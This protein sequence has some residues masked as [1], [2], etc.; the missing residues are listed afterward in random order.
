MH[1]EGISNIVADALSRYFMEHPE[2]EETLPHQKVNVD[3]RLDPE[4]EAIPLDRKAEILQERAIRVSAARRQ[5]RKPNTRDETLGEP[6]NVE[7]ED[8]RAIDH[9]TKGEPLSVRVEGDTT[10]VPFI[11]EGYAQDSTFS[12]V[13]EHPREHPRFGVKDGLIW[14]KNLLKRDTLCVPSSAQKD[15]KRLVEIIINHSHNVV[16]HFGHY[17]TTQHV[18]QSYWWPSMASD[19]EEFCRSCGQCQTTKDSSSRP[20]GLLHS[21][22]IPDRPWQS[23]G[24]DFMGPLPTSNHHD[25]LLVVIDRFTSMVHLI[26]TTVNITASQVAWLFIKEVVKLHGIPE[27]I[28][29]DRDVRFTSKFW[30]ELHRIMGTKLLMSTSFHP[31]TDGATERAN[32]SI[33]Q[34]LRTV[35]SNDQTN[36]A[37]KCPMVEF[38]INGSISSTTG[39]SPFEL[40][41]GYTPTIGI[42]GT[43]SSP[44]KGVQ[45]FAR[46]ARYNLMAAHD[47]IIEQRVK[48]THNANRARRDAPEY[49]EGQQVY[50]STKNLSI[51]KGRSRKLAPRFIGPYRI[52]VVHNDSSNVT[53]DLPE[54]LKKRKVHPTF[55]ASLIRAHIPNDDERFPKRDTQVLYDLGENDETEW[56]VDEI[57]GHHWKPNGE[58]EFRVQ[59]TLGDVTWEPLQ[60]C[61]ELEALDKYLELH[62]VKTPQQLAKRGQTT[63]QK[64]AGVK[65]CRVSVLR[66]K[67]IPKEQDNGAD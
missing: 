43:I 32:R 57:I 60:N 49:Q 18:R 54:D 23:V 9:G 19:I 40:N 27:S 41:Y 62:G 13:L 45:A 12:K 11:K 26:P 7:L 56:Y 39:F 52:I 35:V 5:K 16:G 8:I 59:W 10:L 28:V 14:T 67:E 22:P 53:L 58:V 4:M 34:I 20:M 50:L 31:Q 3:A 15:G 24:I 37:E 63:T 33:G 65:Q 6:T 36:W 47:A 64:S 44:Y 30:R 25:Y 61:N 46:Q 55:H 51:P 2:G 48:Q 1:V 29:S 38:A 66:G 21:L 17:K 42:A